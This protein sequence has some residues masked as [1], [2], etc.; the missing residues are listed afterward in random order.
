MRILSG[1]SDYGL[2][3]VCGTSAQHLARNRILVRFSR[4]EVEGQFR[5]IFKG[6]RYPEKTLVAPPGA[7]A[8]RFL[9]ATPSAEL[10]IV[11]FNPSAAH[12]ILATWI[13]Q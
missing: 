9:Y 1:S 7:I 13:D 11:S 3:K 8:Q 6:L 12:R 4:Y 10:L 2:S 5:W